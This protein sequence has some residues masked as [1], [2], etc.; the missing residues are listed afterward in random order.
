MARDSLTPI[1]VDRNTAET[2]TRGTPGTICL[3]NWKETDMLRLIA[4]LPILLAS[5]SMAF[6]ELP[7]SAGQKVGLD[8]LA[9]KVDSLEASL[10]RLRF[11]L[12]DRSPYVNGAALK[13]GRGL[14]VGMRF[15]QLGPDFELRYTFRNGMEPKDDPGLFGYSRWTI[16]AG[17][18]AAKAGL[19]KN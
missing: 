3:L 19:A 16:V 15:H 18:R 8:S 9:R 10:T 11:D 2:T 5:A 13:W 7:D 17:A 12:Q 1:P 6:T 4:A 14:G